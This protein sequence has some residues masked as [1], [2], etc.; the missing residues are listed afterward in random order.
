MT[1]RTI[2]SLIP[3]D[4]WGA[5]FSDGEGQFMEPLA[6]WALVKEGTRTTV[7]GL[8]ANDKVEL[9][10]EQTNFLSYVNF[11]SALAEAMTNDL[12]NHEHDDEDDDD[13][14]D[15]TDPPGFVPPPPPKRPSRSRLN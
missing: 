6:G 9:C 7:V 13:E 2:Q 11:Q 4:G 5:V 3:A 12:L 10:D 14:G 1:T 8:I 15:D